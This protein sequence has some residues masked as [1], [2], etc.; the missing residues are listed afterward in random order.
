ME[1]RRN[2]RSDLIGGLAPPQRLPT[3]ASCH[4]RFF[5]RPCRPQRPG[6]SFDDLQCTPPACPRLIGSGWTWRQDRHPREVQAHKSQQGG[7][8]PILHGRR[9]GQHTCCH[10]HRHRRQDRG[11]PGPISTRQALVRGQGSSRMGPPRLW[12]GREGT[13][14]GDMPQPSVSAL[15]ETCLFSGLTS[16]G[17]YPNAASQD[18][19]A[20]GYRPDYWQSRPFRAILSRGPKEPGASEA[21]ASHSQTLWVENPLLGR[22]HSAFTSHC[23]GL[24]ADGP[25]QVDLLKRDST[26]HQTLRSIN[27]AN[28]GAGQRGW[29]DGILADR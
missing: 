10:H 23:N 27:F 13:Y 1:G 29:S 4:R 25:G 17:Q 2:R 12:A 5:H 18:S 26:E 14:K 3:I 28:Q 9:L 20:P 22:M 7:P 21:S 6:H 16:T 24:P 19:G 15:R 11:R 8:Q